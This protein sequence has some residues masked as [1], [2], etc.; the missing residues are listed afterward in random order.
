MFPF[1]SEESRGLVL[2]VIEIVAKEEKGLTTKNKNKKKKK[3]KE[4]KKK[5]KKER[6]KYLFTYGHIVQRWKTRIRLLGSSP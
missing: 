3:K 4:K 6:K 2:M 5:R 1:D